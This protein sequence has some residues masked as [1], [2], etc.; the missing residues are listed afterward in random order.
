MGNEIVEAGATSAQPFEFDFVEPSL[1]V[2]QGRSGEMAVRI[3]SMAGYA[4]ELALS[5]TAVHKTGMPLTNVTVVAWPDR[6]TISPDEPAI[7]MVRV[8]LAP[9]AYPGNFYR[10]GVTARA[11]APLAAAQA[12]QAVPVAAPAFPASAAPQTAEAHGELYEQTEGRIG[13]T[14]TASGAPLAGSVAAGEGAAKAGEDAARAKAATAPAEGNGGAASGAEAAQPDASTGAEPF[15]AVVPENPG[16]TLHLVADKKN[17]NAWSTFWD[18]AGQWAQRHIVGTMKPGGPVLGGSKESP[19]ASAGLTSEDTG[20][21]LK[22]LDVAPKAS[23][24]QAAENTK[25]FVK[26][27]IGQTAAITAPEG[28]A[29]EEAAGGLAAAKTIGEKVA[30]LVKNE[31][32]PGVHLIAK[33]VGKST[34]QLANRLAHEMEKD[35]VSSFFNIRTAA[36]MAARTIQDNKARI[37]DWLVNRPRTTLQLE[38]A[39]DPHRKLGQ[40]LYRGKIVSDD[41]YDAVVV[42][43]GDGQGSYNVLTAFPAKAPGKK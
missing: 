28:K 20:G 18:R 23:Q 12:V 10:I 16:G 22:P 40:I 15:P 42:L 25:K 13:E 7:A 32:S 3:R 8:Q 38:V 2:P 43:K 39:G 19:A 36:D 35:A 17:E 14:V 41:A 24:K 33:H 21:A 6:V 1:A 27:A 37:D 31:N 30:A 9:K 11:V 29:G 34:E 5:G 26:E 4:G